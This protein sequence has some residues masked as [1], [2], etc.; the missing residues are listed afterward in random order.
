MCAAALLIV[1]PPYA[2]PM[3]IDA[4]RAV[5][6]AVLWYVGAGR[7]VGGDGAADAGNAGRAR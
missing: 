1:R 4:L 3:A 7:G 2:D 6:G 5:R